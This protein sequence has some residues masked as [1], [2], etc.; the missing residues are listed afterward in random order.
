[1]KTYITRSL[2][3]A[4]AIIA[5]ISCANEINE[6]T[7]NPSAPEQTPGTSDLVFTAAHEGVVITKTS[8]SSDLIPE[9]VSGDVIGITSETDNNV[10]CRLI[11]PEEGTFS[12]EYVTGEALE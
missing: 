3:A 12:G 7:T 10:E 2:F 8:L 4:C 5:A 11:T 1:M 6:P 9:W